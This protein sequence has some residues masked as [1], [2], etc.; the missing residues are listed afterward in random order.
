MAVGHKAAQVNR[1]QS[2]EHLVFH[3]KEFGLYYM[4]LCFNTFI[5][6]V[7]LWEITIK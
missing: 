6:T 5:S 2:W 7:S 1:S 4:A 3:A